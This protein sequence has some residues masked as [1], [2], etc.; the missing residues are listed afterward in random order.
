VRRLAGKPADAMANY[1]RALELQ[2]N[3]G[4]AVLG[5]AETFE[6]MGRAADAQMA[7]ERAIALRPDSP[8]FFNRYGAFC[9]RRGN[10]T[11]AAELFRSMTE[12]L[13]DAARGYANLGGALLALGRYDEALAAYE[14]SIAI[15]PSGQAYSNVGTAR[16]LLG[17]YPEACAAFEK[18]AQ[19]SPSNYMIWA[20]L[21]DAYRW[22]PAKKDEA[23]PAY[24]RAIAGAR[25]AFATNS[26]D[27]LAA[28]TIAACLAKNGRLPEAEEQIRTALTIDPTDS[29]VLYFAAVVAEL[30]GDH[31]H[32]ADWLLRAINSGYSFAAAA[33][34]PEIAALRNR[35][36][37][38][39]ALKKSA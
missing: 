19:L 36:E 27:A 4:D 21:G 38:K 2:P 33:R 1:R 17:R 11:K 31:D 37:I 23:P 12:L 5:T 18:A 29:T 14:K 25:V 35:E 34:A 32:A 26:H 28:A 8:N 3:L 7:F 24:D 13:P 15:S 20:N 9:F 39:R 16:F 22:N 6:A 10:Y 30:D